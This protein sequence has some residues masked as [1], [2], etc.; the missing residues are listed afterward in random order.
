MPPD[1]DTLRAIA[2][3]TGGEFTEARTAGTLETA[4]RN[5]GSRLGREPGHSEITWLFV[6]LAAG[7]LLL[8]GAFAT[9]VSPRLP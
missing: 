6:A 4:Y 3:T 2:K 8:A 9:V 5:L 1:P 7:L